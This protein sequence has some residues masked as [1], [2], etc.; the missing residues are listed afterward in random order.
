MT[1]TSLDR[2]ADDHEGAPWAWHRTL[3]E[4]DL[5]LGVGLHHLEVEGGDTRGAP[6]RPAILVPL[7]TLAGVAQAPIDP[8]ERC[9]LWLPWEA[10]WPLKLCRFIPP[11]KPLPLLTAVT[12]TL[13]PAFEHPGVDLLADGVAIGSSSAQLDQ[14]LAGVDAGRGEVARL[15]LG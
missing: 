15:G 1:T 5:A 7:N 11:A 13:S 4:H 6:I 9:F 12:S 10:P 2:V 3:Q 14:A 8:G